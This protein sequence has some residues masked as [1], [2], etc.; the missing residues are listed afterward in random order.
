[1][2]KDTVYYDILG[3]EPT[4]N[5]L[6]LK[7]AYRK[8]AIKLHPD[9]NANDP[10]AAEK[11]QEL[12]EA[13]GILKDPDTRAVYDEFGVEGMKEKAA[14]GEAA[15]FDPSE[16]FTM[17]F[18]GEAFK[19][20]IG[21]LSMLSEISKTAEV[22][23]E[24][25]EETSKTDSTANE[26]TVATSNADGTVST[27]SVSENKVNEPITSDT[28][29]KAK[30]KKMTKEQRE[31]VMK[32]YEESKIAKQ[33][34]V[35]ELAKNL[36]SRIESYQSAVGNADALKQFTSKLRTEFED[37]KIE[38]F[39]IQ[40]LHLIGKIYTDK[41]HA[42]IRSTKTLGVSKIFSSVKNKTETIKNGYNIL[43]TAMDAQQSAVEMLERQEQ[44]AAA[45]AMGYEASQEELYE[46]AEMERI[47]TG[48]FLATAWAS[49]KF[50]VTDVLTKVCHKVL[51][52][53]S[54]SKK[55]KVSRANAV[56]FIGKELLQVQRSPEEEEE[57]RIFEEM[58]AEAKAKKSK[59]KRSKVSEKDI[60]EYMKR[61]DSSQEESS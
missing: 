56:L 59:K 17:V 5:D 35:D 31:E 43:S 11:F 61:M 24:N 51:S 25:D 45:Q 6:E 3:V 32:M 42:T 41:A 8:Q 4:A 10:N 58:M 46:Q 52:D 7:K 27:P 9:K 13:Y 14:A 21:E 22:L 36:L 49:T 44:L 23:E 48:K 50:E 19:D 2:V 15:E 37:L 39:G 54:I 55:E 30:K 18:G 20:W 34:R 29:K 40:L 60:E 57:A 16:F 26:Q 38:S 12:G 33:K 53:K 1:M 47:I 28:I